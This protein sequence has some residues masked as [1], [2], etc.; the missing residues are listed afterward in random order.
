MMRSRILNSIKK[1]FYVSKSIFRFQ[2]RTLDI[3]ISLILLPILIFFTVIFFIFKI[4]KKDGE[5][6]FIQKRMGKD[7]KPFHA[8]KFRT[9][10][11]SLTVSRAFSDQ[12]E[13]DRI[14]PF[15]HT[16]RKIRLDEL[17]QIIN[18]LKGEMSLIGPRPD[19]YEH[20]IKFLTII[21]TYRLRYS[22][23]PGI[24]GLSQVRLGYAEGVNA[25]KK[26]SKVDLYYINNMCFSL[27][28]KIF[29]A[30]I[31]TIVKALGK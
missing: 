6:F 2:K 15:G 5:I 31:W 21:P 25:T 4:F 13:Y 26:K 19:S 11:K 20:A 27:D 17:P 3:T 29:F 1:S 8:I 14:T 9:M 22:I 23:K 16:L 18:V 28:S 12:L 10:T 24:S 30:T 7:L